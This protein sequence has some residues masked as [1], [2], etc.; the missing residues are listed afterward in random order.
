M[1]APDLGLVAGGFDYAVVL[2]DAIGAEVVAA[3]AGAG[4]ALSRSYAAAT[5][6]LAY[7]AATAALAVAL[8]LF[9]A[10]ATPTIFLPAACERCG[11]ADLKVLM[12]RRAVCVS[13]RWG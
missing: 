3:G 10:G 8:F 2:F 9:V 11:C 12:V 13:V 7:A 6:A 5:A 4:V 1:V